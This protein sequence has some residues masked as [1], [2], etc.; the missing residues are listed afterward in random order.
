MSADSLGLDAAKREALDR[1]FNDLPTEYQPLVAALDAIDQAVREKFASH[2]E[3]ALNR[4]I[5]DPDAH[6]I[7]SCTKKTDVVDAVT[8]RFGLTT[9]DPDTQRPA[10]LTA[11]NRMDGSRLANYAYIVRAGR[12]RS[13]YSYSSRSADLAP[14]KLA[15][16]PVDFHSWADEFRGRGRGRGR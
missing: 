2:L 11:V 12:D 6:T 4:R 7:K 16:A 15:P 5:G 1:L 8:R 13:G 3:P 10:L 14:V 9:I